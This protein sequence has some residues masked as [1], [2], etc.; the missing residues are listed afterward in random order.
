MIAG[1]HVEIDLHDLSR[2]VMQTDFCVIRHIAV[3]EIPQPKDPVAILNVTAESFNP[4]GGHVGLCLM[5]VGMSAERDVLWACC[6]MGQHRD[7][8]TIHL[9][10]SLLVAPEVIGRTSKLTLRLYGFRRVL[11][12]Q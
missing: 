4:N 6:L 8:E 11:S 10:E 5:C 7:V 1:S 9:V 12:P 2:L 3:D